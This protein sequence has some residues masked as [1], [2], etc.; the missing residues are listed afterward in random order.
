VP[1]TRW[2]KSI[3]VGL[4]KVLATRSKFDGSCV[5]SMSRKRGRRECDGSLGRK[6]AIQG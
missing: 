6:W 4:L 5:R 3:E 1:S 2:G